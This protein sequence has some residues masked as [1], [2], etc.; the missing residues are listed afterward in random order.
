MKN[1]FFTVLF[2][3]PKRGEYFRQLFLEDFSAIV[4]NRT[5]II[6]DDNDLKDTIKVSENFLEIILSIIALILSTSSKTLNLSIILIEKLLPILDKKID[7]KS[8]IVKLKNQ[9]IVKIPIELFRSGRLRSILTNSYIHISRIYIGDKKYHDALSCLQKGLKLGAD[10]IDCFTGLAL[11]HFYL[12]DLEKAED[13]TNEINGQRKNKPVYFVNKA[14][15]SIKQKKYKNV[16]YY[17][18]NLKKI[19]KD[20]HTV[21][22]RASYQILKRKSKRRSR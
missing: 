14:F 16:Q 11:V 22:N 21:N 19:Y 20:E 10:K 7:P 8:K 1:S 4:Q 3:K 18:S 9:P 6:D 17:Y 13:Y 5:W 15:F 12:G 2:R